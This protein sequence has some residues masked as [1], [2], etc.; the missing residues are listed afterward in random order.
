LEWNWIELRYV[1]RIAVR[2]LKSGLG[3]KDRQEDD[4]LLKVEVGFVSFLGR[5]K[6]F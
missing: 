3:P 5:R 6:V 1:R 4:E 2:V